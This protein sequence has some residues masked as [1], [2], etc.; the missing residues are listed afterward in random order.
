MVQVL[1]SF[2]TSGLS[3]TIRFRWRRALHQILAIVIPNRVEGFFFIEKQWLHK[4]A[5]IPLRNRHPEL[6]SGS[7]M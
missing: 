2:L 3:P 7:F 4:N 6:V 5:T 1:G